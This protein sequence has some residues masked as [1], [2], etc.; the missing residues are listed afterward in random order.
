M[1]GVKIIKLVATKGLPRLKTSNRTSRIG[2]N[3]NVQIVF[4][5]HWYESLR[6]LNLEGSKLTE[7]LPLNQVL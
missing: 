2:H 6:V 1:F 7:H 4:N 3:C 5:G